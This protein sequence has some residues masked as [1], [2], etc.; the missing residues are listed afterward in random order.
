MRQKSWCFKTC[1]TF[2]SLHPPDLFSKEKQSVHPLPRPYCLGTVLMTRRPSSL[3]LVCH[4]MKKTGQCSSSQ[5][6][7][8]VFLLPESLTQKA[9]VGKRC[10]LCIMGF[11]LAWAVLARHVL[12]KHGTLGRVVHR[13]W[14]DFLINI[15]TYTAYKNLPHCQKSN[16]WSNSLQ[17]P[18]WVLW[19]WFLGNPAPVLVVAY[20]CFHLSP[21]LELAVATGMT[22]VNLE[23]VFRFVHL[24]PKTKNIHGAGDF[25]LL[26]KLRMSKRNQTFDPRIRTWGQMVTG[27][28]PGSLWKPASS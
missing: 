15:Q 16:G 20:P 27:S 9:V 3:S 2:R 11:A 17:M 7:K 19:V 13:I 1:S 18:L 6:P 24:V 8:G 12:E 28:I 14:K 22:L 25:L 10:H 5:G 26:M 23:L 21:F 4:A